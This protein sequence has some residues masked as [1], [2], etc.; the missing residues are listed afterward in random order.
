MNAMR[1]SAWVGSIRPGR[2]LSRVA[3]S[4]EDTY[5]GTVGTS[6]LEA[7]LLSRAS[8]D[9]ARESVDVDL[10][11]YLSAKRRSMNPY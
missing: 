7:S 10:E 3:N 5:L 8:P 2:S 6:L 9:A 1:A 11:D 4:P